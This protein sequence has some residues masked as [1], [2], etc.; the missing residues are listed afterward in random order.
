MIMIEESLSVISDE[1]AMEFLEFSE[2]ASEDIQFTKC[3]IINKYSKIY[4]D[5]NLILRHIKIYWYQYDR[6]L[7]QKNNDNHSHAPRCCATAP[8][9]NVI[10][11]LCWNKFHHVTTTMSAC[12]LC[13][14]MA[15]LPLVAWWPACL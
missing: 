12:L 1:I 7:Q 11:I 2:D 5:V 4:K 10:A 6:S 13:G 3:S 9:K 14:L 15:C 8:A